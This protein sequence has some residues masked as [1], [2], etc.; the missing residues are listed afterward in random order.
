MHLF[1]W[2][3]Q[4]PCIDMPRYLLEHRGGD[5][6]DYR[7]W[8]VARHFQREDDGTFWQAC[9]PLSNRCLFSTTAELGFDKSASPVARDHV[10]RRISTLKQE[11]KLE[12]ELANCR[13]RLPQYQA[14]EAKFA[15][16]SKT[17]ADAEGM[18]GYWRLAAGNMVHRAKAGIHLASKALGG[19]GDAGERGALLEQLQALR[20]QCETMYEPMIKPTRR[21]EILGWLYDSI[22]EALRTV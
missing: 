22:E 18:L 8:F 6:E 19:G 21:S 15:E 1:P 14:A 4:W 11:G 2:E 13:V 17:W 20:G 12:Q 10:A 16:M 3:L 5:L 7:R 9:G